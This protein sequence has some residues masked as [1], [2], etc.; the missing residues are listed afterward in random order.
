MHKRSITV[1]PAH[2]TDEQLFQFE[3][4]E[5]SPAES[6]H[7]SSCGVCSGRLHDMQAAAAAYLEYHEA[8]RKPLRPPQEWRSLG[9]LIADRKT[10]RRVTAF[11][12]RPVP[13]LAAGICIVLGLAVLN[14]SSQA[15]SAQANDLLTRSARTELPAGRFISVRLHSRTLVRSAA[16]NTDS[17]PGGDAEMAHLRTLFAVAHYSWREPLSSQSFQAWRSGLKRKRDYVSVIESSGKKSY[18]VRTDSPNGDLRSAALTLRAEDLRPTS[19]SF[20]FLGEGTV[21][22]AETDSVV[23]SDAGRSSPQVTKR[24]TEYPVGPADTLHVLSALDS[25]GAD[26]GEPLDLTDDSTHRHVVVHAYG[27]TRERQQQIENVLKPLPRVALNFDTASP[28]G[29]PGQHVSPETLTSSIPD[30]MRHQLEAS[31]G[32]PAALQEVT[33]RVLDASATVVARSRALEVLASHFPPEVEAELPLQDQQVLRGL[34]HTHLQA[35]NRLVESTRTKLKPVFTTSPVPPSAP[36]TDREP[37][38]PWQTT[39]PSL[40]SSAQ[41]LDQSLNHLLAGSYS[42]PQGE[43]LIRRLP[44]EIEHLLAVIQSQGTVEK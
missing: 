28:A 4:G 44:G 1:H 9:A 35:L 26:V 39:V 19:G 13:A 16:Y 29:I 25:I 20:D 32:G 34:R 23:E 37:S 6:S 38:A 11:L 42:Q 2:L 36:T 41:E 22:I 10:S 15:P 7:V 31:L 24:S 33:D 8:V 5:L 30:P 27:I 17:P 3:D 12:W 18:H 40:M 21:E 14:R 43:E